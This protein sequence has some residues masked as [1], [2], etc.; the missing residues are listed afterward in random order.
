MNFL[1]INTAELSSFLL[2]K[3]THFVN[4]DN[5]IAI[6]NDDGTWS[7]YYTDDEFLTYEKL[8]E[9]LSDLDTFQSRA[10]KLKSAMNLLYDYL[11]QQKHDDTMFYVYEAGKAV[12]GEKNLRQFFS[13]VYLA[14]TLR[15]KEGGRLGPFI[16]IL[17]RE[18]FFS[19]MYQN[20]S[21]PLFWRLV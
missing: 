20:M 12:Y 11:I 7:E 4:P 17:G 2:M 14:L 1:D 6:Q 13:D 3:D 21:A 15:T 8:P 18:E 9:M 10:Y 16:D 19:K 5:Y